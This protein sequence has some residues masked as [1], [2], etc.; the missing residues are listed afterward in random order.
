MFSSAPADPVL[1]NLAPDVVFPAAV[2]GSRE[3]LEV[4]VDAAA[5]AAAEL[6]AAD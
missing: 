2:S 3:W 5:V 1:V 6:P 4:V